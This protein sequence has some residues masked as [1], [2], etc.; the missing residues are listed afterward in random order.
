MLSI[1]IQFIFTAV[2]AVLTGRFTFHHPVP[3][4]PP[5]GTGDHGAVPFLFT[6]SVLGAV[7][8]L[9]GGL[10]VCNFFNQM[11][12][13]GN[14]RRFFRWVLRYTSPCV[15]IIFLLFVAGALIVSRD[16][17]LAYCPSVLLIFLYRD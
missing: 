10:S 9:I 15:D 12:K 11:A 13:H 7:N 16:N 14:K 8:I 17:P 3:E 2:A 5:T 1:E 6:V 4:Y